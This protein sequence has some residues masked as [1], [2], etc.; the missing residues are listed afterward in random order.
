MC[1]IVGYIGKN[2]ATPILIEGLR[3]EI[4]R[5]YDSSG[6]VVFQNGEPFCVKAVGKLENLEAKLTNSSPVG[7]IGLGHCLPPD[8]LIQ[9]VDGS[10]KEIS[11]IK[12]GDK[13]L[14]LNQETLKFST[15]KV[16]VYKHK[17]PQ[18]LYEI[19]TPS[20]SLKTTGQHKMLVVVN[21]EI[22]EKKVEEIS[23][24]DLLIFP[25]QIKIEGRKIQFKEVE[26]KRYYKITSEISQLIKN[27]ILDKELST[28]KAAFEVGVRDSYIEHI[29]RNDRN[30]REDQL[31]KIL[32][33]FSIQ[34]P[35]NEFTP[36]NT[37]HGKFITLPKESSPELMQISGYLLGDGDVK[38]RCIRFKDLD[39]D[40]LLFYRDLIEKVFNVEGRVV[41]Q[42]GTRAYLLEVNSLYLCNW[43]RENIVLRKK[44]FL[45]EVGQLPKKEIATFLRGLFDAEGCVALKAGQICFT[46]TNEY[47]AKIILLL[48]LRFGLK[49]SFYKEKRKE[50][51]WRDRC[52]IYFSNYFSFKKFKKEV[53]FSSKEK[54]EKLEFLIK[55]RDKRAF[56]K[57]IGNSDIIPQKILN[58]RK[59]KSDIDCL[60]DLEV[61]PYSNFIANGLLSHN[62]RWAT[63]GGVTEANAHPHCD[64]QKNIYLVHNGIIE[65]YK[66]LKEKLEKE[67]HKFYSQCDSEVLCHLIEK[68]FQGNLETAVRKALKFI[69]GTYGLAII[70]R[71]D[72]DKIVVARNSSPIL[73]GIGEDEHIVASDAAAIVNR[74]KKVIYLNDGEIAVLTPEKFFIIDS[75]QNQVQKSAEEIEWDIEEAQKGDYPHFMLK[76]IMEEPETIENAIRGRLIIEEGKVKLGGLEGIQ[77]KLREIKRIILVA[78]GTASYAARVGEYMLEEYA[79][80]PAEVDI[81]SEFRY[82][83]PVVD[84]NTAA[85]FV[86][87][88]GETADTL[89]AL[90]E[91]KEK[92]ILTIG[93]TNVVGS[94]QTRETEAGIYTRSGPEIAVASTKAFLGQLAILSMLAVYLGRQREI[95]LVMGKRIVSELAK[96]PEL[97]RETLKSAPEIEKLAKK[98]KDFKNFWFIGRKYNFPVALEGAL[99]L[100]E[101]SYLHAEGVAGGELKHGPLALIDENFPTIAICPSDSV[102]EKMISNIEE[103]KA[104]EGLV[105]AIATEGNE[106]I[107]KIVDDVIYIPKTLEMLTPMLSVIPLHLFAYYM[108]VL[109][110]NDV[111][112]PRNLAKVITVE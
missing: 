112:K 30:F 48:F 64:C 97:A 51:H 96:L 108:A 100:K 107:K 5:G 67:G 78:C 29:I 33:F 84:K 69:R 19:R 26:I 54:S 57:D 104:R 80:I 37:I 40:L 23:K 12:N 76:E 6:I 73:I 102:Y 77:E 63:H 17:S 93:I 49:A 39:K 90:K 24:G 85:I 16:E 92:G 109:L 70:A 72:P 13:V 86:S 25:K 43:L 7:E 68:F 95:A 105:I 60:F 36:Q 103:I 61:N 46:N 75:N 47:L 42:N 21:N 27:R 82:R 74:T 18:Y 15:G 71:N 58:I 4:Y 81:A 59:I 2:N 11:K 44:E 98:Y 34:F 22:K 53:G 62:S 41:P 99:K 14:S 32:P 79:G 111:D 106:D 83:K 101:I 52:V 65:N 110:G 50:K 89:A 94:T 10:I 45:E 35:S 1:G 9:L 91:M 3:R 55:K 87:Q 20:A 88:S 28:A 38:K 8:T 56:K 66:E 31:Q